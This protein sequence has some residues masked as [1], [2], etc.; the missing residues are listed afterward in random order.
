MSPRKQNEISLQEIEMEEMKRQIQ[1]L[2]ET[3]NAQKALL[4]A[5]RRRV[6]DDGSSIDFSLYRSSPHIDVNLR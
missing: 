4:E 1:Q 3:I 6:D 2:Q 5:Q